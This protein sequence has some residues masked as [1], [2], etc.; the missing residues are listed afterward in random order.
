MA[1]ITVPIK[2]YRKILA[3]GLH[4]AIEDDCL[5]EFLSVNDVSEVLNINIEQISVLGLLALKRDNRGVITLLNKGA[6]PIHTSYDQY[7]RSS[8]DLACI[9]KYCSR[10]VYEMAVDRLFDQTLTTNV[11]YKIFASIFEIID[12]SDSCM[13][14]K[15]FLSKL[16]EI[17]QLNTVINYEKSFQSLIDIAYGLYKKNNNSEGFQILLESGINISSRLEDILKSDPNL[18]TLYDSYQIGIKEPDCE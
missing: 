15:Y 11:L 8:T 12:G 2:S 13:K 16:A 14:C 17:G 4:Q 10:E 6:I 5:D 1:T 3:F 7:D 18:K 9:L